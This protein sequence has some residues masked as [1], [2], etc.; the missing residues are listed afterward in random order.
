LDRWGLK[1]TFF[2]EIFNDKI[3]SKIE[4]VF[5]L[6]KDAYVWNNILYLFRNRACIEK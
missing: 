3:F 5:L 4:N 2:A 1:N 6:E